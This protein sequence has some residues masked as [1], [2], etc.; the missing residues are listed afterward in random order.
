MHPH[1]PRCGFYFYFA[2]E[3]RVLHHVVL[4]RLSRRTDF[5][6]KL[7]NTVRWGDMKFIV[8][9]GIFRAEEDFKGIAFQKREV[10]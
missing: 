2:G 3:E 9:G 4:D 1:M 10:V 7:K 5:K 8:M 6:A